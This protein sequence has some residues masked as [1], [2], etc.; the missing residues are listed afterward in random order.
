MR[1]ADFYSDARSDL[2]GPLAGV[3][4]LEITTTWA[5]PMCGAVL[6]DFGADVIKVEIQSGDVG[7][8]IMPYLPDTEVGFAHATVNRNKRALTLDIRTPEGRDICHQLAA[9]C[10]L[11]VENFKVGTMAGYGLGYEDLRAIKED[12]VYVSITGWGQF[13]PRFED[14]GYDPLAQ[15]TSGF[16]TVNGSPDGPPTKAGTFLADDLGGLHAALGALAALR[17]RD[18]TGEGQHVDIA[19]LDAMLFQS[20][21]LPT[22][23]AMGVEPGRM[24][25]EFG[26]A[27]PSNVYQCADGPIYAGVLLDSHWQ[28]LAELIGA[29]DLADNEAFATREARVGNRDLCNQLF[30]DWLGQRTRAEAAAELNQRGLAVAPVQTFVETAQDP[31]VLERDMLQPTEVAAGVTAPIT[32]P[33]AKFSRTPTRVRSAAPA[34]G[35]HN[36]EILEELGVDAERRAELG[37]AGVLS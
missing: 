1:K 33:A 8:A 23:G 24:G 7:R 21:G 2:T 11:F 36:D 29:P 22:L 12:I 37:A 32:G 3:R 16:M 13:G 4:V 14:A 6:A 19:L 15:A 5:G 9:R 31:H 26:F 34:M 30:G 35:Q 27:V 18:Q 10:D 20:N 17:H 25:N 28:A